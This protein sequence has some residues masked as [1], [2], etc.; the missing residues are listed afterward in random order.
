MQTL[1]HFRNI[2]IV[3]SLAFASLPTV[4]RAGINGFGDFSQWTL[5]QSDTDSPPTLPAP[6]AIQLTNSGIG[7]GRSLF[8]NVPQD[9]T[10]FSTSF[11]YQALT[12]DILD[13]SGAALVLQNSPAGAH[14]IGNYFFAYGNLPNS[15]AITLESSNATGVYTNGNMSGGSASTSPVNLFSGDPINVSLT[16]NGTMLQ[17]TLTDT[18]TASSFSKSYFINIPGA[19]GSST[20]FVGFTAGTYPLSYGGTGEQIISNVHFPVPEPSSLA[21]LGLGALGLLTFTLR[22]RRPK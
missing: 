3:A 5:N 13:N 22:S 14:A 19:I 20:A 21:L 4:V 7:E 17:E 9:V 2:L 18:I 11:I 1:Q 16:Y 6:D 15:V 12:D 8:Y 10:H